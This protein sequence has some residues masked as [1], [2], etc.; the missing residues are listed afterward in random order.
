VRKGQVRLSPCDPLK[1]AANPETGTIQ[2]GYDN[3]GNLLSK[4]D[5]RV[6]VSFGSYD[7]LGRPT[8]KS[9]NNGTPTVTYT[10]ES[11]P[12]GRGRLCSV[13]TSGSGNEQ[14]MVSLEYDSVGRVLKRTQSVGG[15]AYVVN[16]TYWAG[17]LPRQI[18]YPTSQSGAVRRVSYEYWPNGQA[19]EVWQGLPGSGSRYAYL[20]DY[21]AGGNPQSVTLGSDLAVG[22][23]NN[24]QENGV[25]NER[26]QMLSRSW[27][28]NG[29]NLLTLGLGYGSPNNG[30]LRTQTIGGMHQGVAFQ[31]EQ[32]FDYDAVNRLRIFQDNGIVN[33][34]NAAARQQYVFDRFGNRA[35]LAGS[36]GNPSGDFVPW[37][38]QDQE[39]QV[40]QKFPNNR[41]QVDV[42]D[43]AG[44]GRHDN[45]GNVTSASGNAFE[46]DGENR[47]VR[48]V[49]GGFEY[50]YRY[51]GEG[52]RVAVERWTGGVMDAAQTR[53]FVYGVGG[54]LLA[55]IQGPVPVS[56]E[57]RYFGQD[58]LGSTRVVMRTDATGDAAVVSRHDYFPFGEELPDRGR[59]YGNS[60]VLV[61]FTG[62]ERDG[63]TG[64]DY[65]GARYM[66]S[67]Q[68][69]FTS[70]DPLLASAVA[71]I[72]QSW[73]RYSYGL[74]NPLRFIDP[75][76][77]AWM[78]S[79]GSTWEWVNSCGGLA[80][81][82]NCR[83]AVA[84]QTQQGVTVYGSTNANDITQYASNDAGVVDVSVIA[85]HHDSNF[86][87]GPQTVEENY[88]NPQ[89]AAALFN[90]AGDYGTAIGH[91][92]DGKLVFTA[93]SAATG[94][95]GVN[96]VT[97]QPLHQS[98]Q[99]GANIDM[100]YM[101][102]NGQSLIGNNAAS[103]GDINRNRAIMNLFHNAGAG[104]GA[105]LTGDPQRYGLAAISQGLQRIHR[106][107]MHF[108]R[109]YPGVR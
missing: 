53:R 59:N 16:Q 49:A 42:M 28:K 14:T 27:T 63:E 8:G 34:G 47:Q 30:N 93:G 25:Q 6:T 4:A 2:Y 56:W 109:Q 3:A 48:A 24:I 33:C 81:D 52:R 22:S 60:A 99:G 105:A 82:V 7:A 21:Q 96:P 20:D 88:L 29:L 50:R 83:S 35:M 98:H 36:C 46:Y 101:G 61:K 92:R 73:N 54:E 94:G 86:L 26:G 72:P 97:G 89:A 84:V 23:S 43:T 69:R 37:V 100:R 45:S 51:D 31:F 77:M 102:A 107:H 9:Y 106:N 104:L 76:G 1:S 57:R 108:Q 78:Q 91:G 70:N 15:Q 18:E 67:A 32:A 87:I 58:H 71:E 40:E 13:S 90:V 74:N 11:C 85:Q 62:K 79:E 80:P 44:T 41:W 19:K 66:S 55:E 17:G 39:T 65:F 10:Y 95:P 38:A 5:G 103:T 64:L 12:F 75:T 68:G